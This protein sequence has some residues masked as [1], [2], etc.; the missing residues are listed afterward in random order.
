MVTTHISVVRLLAKDD[1]DENEIQ[2]MDWGLKGVTKDENGY[3][4]IGITVQ[5]GYMV[6]VAREGGDGR[7]RLAQ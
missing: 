6:K 7:V 3:Q 2:R 4:M 1:E 5:V